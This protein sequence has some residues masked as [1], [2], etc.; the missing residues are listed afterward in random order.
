M[1]GWLFEYSFLAG[2]SYVLVWV[3]HRIRDT[4]DSFLCH[5]AE[6]L[7]S[8]HKS[9][10]ILVIGNEACD[11][12]STA[13]ALAYGFYKKIKL[14]NEFIVI[15]I[16]NIN[17]EDMVLRT[18]VTFWL[19]QCGL[20]WE[21]LIYLDDMFDESRS[22]VNENELFLILVDHHLPTEKFNKW[23]LIEI[24][25]HHQLVNSE[26][27]KNCPFKQISFVGSCSSL[28]TFEILKN[29]DSNNL[30]VNVWKLL[31]GAILI[32][33]IGLSSAGQIAG[34]LTELDFRM[35]NRIED[36]IYNETPTAVISRNS[37]FSKLETAKFNTEGLSTWDLLRRDVK[38]VSSS[39]KD[40]LQIVCSTVSGLDFTILI[41]SPDFIESANQLCAKYNANLLI[42]FTVGYPL[43]ESSSVPS[44]ELTTFRR[45]ALI[46][47]NVSTPVV[48]YNNL[49]KFLS[50]PKR[51]LDLVS[52]TIPNFDYF[53]AIVN[54]VKMTRKLFIPLLVQF[55]QQ[56]GSPGGTSIADNNSRN[57]N[58]DGNNSS[59]II[60][61][62][63]P[64][65]NISQSNTGNPQS[66]D[67]N[68]KC[69]V[70]AKHK[71]KDTIGFIPKDV[72]LS[73]RN[74]LLPLRPHERCA[75]LRSFC[76]SSLNTSDSPSLDLLTHLW[77]SLWCG[78][79]NTSKTVKAAVG[80]QTPIS[81]LVWLKSRHTRRVGSLIQG[82][83]SAIKAVSSKSGNFKTARRFTLPDTTDLGS[84]TEKASKT[85]VDLQLPYF[86]HRRSE[87]NLC[88]SDSENTKP[89]WLETEYLTR[90]PA[91]LPA[92]ITSTSLDSAE[93]VSYRLYRRLSGMPLS[94][95][96]EDEISYDH[97]AFGKDGLDVHIIHDKDE[98]C[99]IDYNI[100]D[101]EELALLRTSLTECRQLFLDKQTSTTNLSSCTSWFSVH[102]DRIT[103][104]GLK[105]LKSGYHL[106]S[107]KT[108]DISM[109]PKLIKPLC[110]EEEQT[111]RSCHVTFDLG[112]TENCEIMI[113]EQRINNFIRRSTMLTMATNEKLNIFHN[114][115]WL[116][117]CT[118][119]F[120]H[121]VHTN[122]FVKLTL[123]LFVKK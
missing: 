65:T 75:F 93:A 59:N 107:T 24:I 105:F 88:V 117:Q 101:D 56:S 38:T 37:L 77:T 29:V 18:E 63:Q 22:K 74:W 16:C 76:R 70:D 66:T 17:R 31:Y 119:N 109:I 121:V 60:D 86:T 2:T 46:L 89:S 47:Y 64:D 6:A 34:R 115:N 81:K 28:I 14:E 118:S 61:E 51:N 27:I 54:N 52:Q 44:S 91:W 92:N 95:N 11:L 43:S 122:F 123:R 110:T 80:T 48:V 69:S 45:R 32:D 5:A 41:N 26:V 25:D 39:N 102:P 94:R 30:P 114:M 20:Q 106:Q 10:W 13:C 12:D 71:V 83:N 120:L 50:D 104:R 42:C 9:K 68:L 112:C 97:T 82:N 100:L 58:D 87:E 108:E 96:Y 55:L 73:L 40:G 1:S 21:Q 85:R 23:P 49:I 99:S 79:R 57:D 19:T 67:P 90:I 3:S 7:R 113:S 35:A 15:P 36:I 103:E 8:S 98:H 72:V 33:T 111:K 4:M 84:Y 116:K 62:P 53:T 78:T